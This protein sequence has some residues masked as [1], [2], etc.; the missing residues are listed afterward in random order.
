LEFAEKNLTEMNRKQ[1]DKLVKVERDL[2]DAFTKRNNSI[3]EQ[4]KL[5]K[6]LDNVREMVSQLEKNL[7]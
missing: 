5:E 4:K 1:I 6:E 3:K 7:S 2:E